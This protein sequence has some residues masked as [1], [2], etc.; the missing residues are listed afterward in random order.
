MSKPKS[1][2]TPSRSLGECVADVKKLYDVYSHAKFDRSEIASKLGRSG[3]SVTSGPFQ[4]RLF[5]LKEFGLL[6]QVGAEHSVSQTFM[7]L[8]STDPATGRFKRTAW[9]AIRRSEVFRELL[10]AFKGKLPAVEAIAQRLEIGKQFNADKAKKSAIVLTESLRYAGVLDNA[11]NIL[12]VRDTTPSDD[13]DRGDRSRD[14]GGLDFTDNS[15]R[16][17]LRVEV[18]IRDGRKIV[19]SYPEDLTADEAKKVGAVMA[20]IVG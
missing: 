16:G 3:V 4:A 9:D 2:P 8:N 12:P 15:A 7:T 14:E 19:V 11:N 18:P 10:D 20:A 1:P 13:R 5:T 6:D 17:T